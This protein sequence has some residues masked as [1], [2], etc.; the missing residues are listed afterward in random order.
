M[1]ITRLHTQIEDWRKRLL[2][3]SKRNR[4]V[5][6]KI[7]ARA[8]ME[9]VH[10]AP[11]SVWQHLVVDDGTMSFA[12]KR[13][14]LD[15]EDDEDSPQLSLFLGESKSQNGEDSAE[16]TSDKGVQPV[17]KGAEME[18][19]LASP[20]LRE[21]HL[22][23]HMT[24]QTLGSRLKRL[25]LNAKTTIAEQGINV[26]YLT[27]GLLR[28]YESPSSDVPLFAPLL[29]VPVK[30]DRAGPDAPWKISL[31]EEEIA[32]NHCLR[33]LLISNYRLELPE[34]P[35]NVL[36]N[37]GDRAAFLKSVSEVV[38]VP[39][40][41]SRWEVMDR[42]LLAT[43]SFQKLAMWQDLGNNRDRIAA[44]DLCRAIAGDDSAP[45]SASRDLPAI[46]DFDEQIHPKD[47]H[48]ILDSDSSQL[49]AIV[50]AKSGMSLVLDGPPGTGKSQTI[51]NI[52]A[53]SLAAG[54]TVL[55]VS[56]KAAAL[57]VVKR[58]LDASNLGDFC[59]ECHSHKANKKEVI[60]ELGRCL[61]LPSEQYNDQSDELVR[62]KSA[63]KRLNAYVCALHRPCSALR[64][65]PYAVHGQLAQLKASHTSRCPIG[66]VLDVDAVTL[67]EITDALRSLTASHAVIE[68]YD[69]HPWRGCCIARFSLTLQD[70][71]AHDFGHLSQ[72]ISTCAQSV[73]ILSQYGLAPEQPN[74]SQA[75]MTLEQARQLLEFPDLPAQWFARNPR[76]I[77]TQLLELYSVT[78]KYQQL[79]QT[80]SVFRG[81]G[82]GTDLTILLG[83][84]CEK[85]SP[86][87]E[88]LRTSPPVTVRTQQAWFGAL[89]DQLAAVRRL[90]GEIAV[91]VD[92]FSRA[93]RVQIDRGSCIG[94]LTKLTA[95]G[96]ALKQTGLLKG[97]WFDDEKR[98]EL[99]QVA[100]NC[101]KQIDEANRVRNDLSE[102]MSEMAFD[103]E[104]ES[105]SAAA[106]EY[107]QFWK[108]FWCRLMGR[109]GRFVRKSA[110]LY[111][112]PAFANSR[113]LL[114]DMAQLRAY[115]ALTKSVIGEEHLHAAD[116]ICDEQ[117]R[118][119][120]R[121]FTSGIEAIDRL[122][123]I[124]KIPDRLKQV[125]TTEGI[126]DRNALDTAT[127]N[128]DS[129]LNDLDNSV[130]L[131]GEQIVL[132][133]IGTGK[134][135]YVDV[136]PAVFQDWLQAI[137]SVVRQRVATLDGLSAPL[138]ATQD[139]A[140]AD[141]PSYVA[142]LDEL[143]RLQNRQDA[144]CSELDEVLNPNSQIDTTVLSP[145]VETA[146][147]IVRFLDTYGDSPQQGV[148]DVVTRNEPR[149]S[150]SHAC[151]T[152][153]S[154]L[155][156]TVEQAWATLWKCFPADRS[157]AN[158]QDIAGKPL[159]CLG[160]WLGE[161][162]KVVDR[163]QEWIRFRETEEALSRLNVLP[164]LNEVLTGEIPIA[165]AAESY[166]AR[167]YRVWL[168]AA[169]S[170][171]A[172]LREFRA[173]KHESLIST[174]RKLDH[175]AIAGA[176]KRIRAK[177]LADTG[178]PHSGMLAVPPG[179]ELGILL[180]EAGK[181]KRHLALRQLF[182]RIPTLLPR[183]KP[184]L[185]MSP[186]AVSTY[187]DSPDLRFDLV[188]FDEAS[189]V[190]PFDA[191]GAVYRGNQIV[192]AGDQKQLPPT[193]FFDHLVSDDDAEMSDDD[194][195]STSRLSD[196][197]SVLDV[198]CSM[199]MPRKRLRWHYRSR[200]EPLIAFSNHH[201]YA[202]E[203]ATFPSVFDAD[204]TSA[205][206]FHFVSNG[207]WRPGSGGGDN[208]CEARET[209]SLVFQ[210][211]ERHPDQSLGVITFNQ[212]QQFA[213]LDEL[214][215]LRRDR[216]EME[217]FFQED[218]EEPLFVKNLENVQGDERDR[219][220][221]SVGY[222]YDE[223][224]KFA[225]RFG[226]LN[227][228]GGERRLNVAITRAKHQV[229]LVTSIHATDID[230]SR[231]QSAGARLLRAYIDYADRG[232]ETLGSEISED[233]MRQAD[234]PFEM[235]VEGALRSQG[236]DVRRQVGCGGFRIDLAVVHPSQQGRYV[237][238]IECDGATYHSSATARDRDRLRQEIL[239]GLGWTICRV[240]STDWVRNPESQIKRIIQA[241]ETAMSAG[242]CEGVQET[243]PEIRREKPVL[244][245]RRD[246]GRHGT[247]AHGF[248]SIDEVPVDVLDKIILGVLHRYGQ[249]THEELIRATAREL[250]FLRVG[251][252]IEAKIG[253]RI[254]AM[255]GAR[256]VRRADGDRLCAS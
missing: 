90:V 76:R 55:F 2:D 163:L 91:A 9:I 39:T 248:S 199:G 176:Y 60:T 51:A 201:F 175:E 110:T 187:L 8:A 184:C 146:N 107:E 186:L 127:R 125:L 95:L 53:E 213:V 144:L 3:L 147:H 11:E 220:I 179:S 165:E 237:L 235:A 22:L 16:G 143:C 114:E 148:L 123:K 231:V 35:E 48:T 208:P 156:E 13:D 43:F 111:L 193:S 159:S 75:E 19:C 24:D 23:T 224:G 209:A 42:V 68:Q 47:I 81:D 254:A 49:E 71:I 136:P 46:E 54:K 104:G 20:F 7:G 63:R 65:T 217:R 168:D 252:R 236:L 17:A 66:N 139:M 30:L 211:L 245:V 85:I 203:L 21:E 142:R 169:Y 141:L 5:N 10:P 185:M 52:I 173:E 172:T 189:Q 161:Q 80:V 33:E 132:S 6:C 84:G 215:R 34:V 45:V 138:E 61:S 221:I 219:I 216:P 101:Q 223:H 233:R 251:K 135:N 4:L 64:M 40:A 206:Q 121:D 240:W 37:A 116:L 230:L 97:S 94:L 194:E 157:S 62:L 228:Q 44:H 212:R 126:L 128:L 174:F 198:C 225:M 241:F 56:E 181:R 82:I 242:D 25:S 29:L 73:A 18:E 88:F 256:S 38:Q 96:S 158:G 118:A 188:I 27:F 151:A 28:W 171:N 190:R 26:L 154:V 41:H 178:R 99:Q 145:F 155:D 1:P 103:A 58:R 134:T 202:N 105:I 93:L 131:L 133:R 137:E 106:S 92:D 200:R 102:R 255:I 14:L 239:E 70:D 36:E 115:H 195:D 227:V 182:R 183:L 98:T 59:L 246:E 253:K 222:G 214:D 247:S 108:R 69:Q 210:I 67:R 207:R 167:F 83:D 226:P 244:R 197:E 117:G 164:V 109:W 232:T 166:L 32:P 87:L 218:R 229:V 177:L 250:G 86:P 15:E 89:A 100:A 150:V 180:R 238:G 77:A 196:F 191:I 170:D 153:R 249:T 130:N 243:P 50:A 160:A 74:K 79:R 119:R 204:G 31:Y 234:S 205:V 113:E 57:E 122:R 192:V 78:D 152:L 140:V 112:Q 120:W 124:I 129:R 12:W 162:A 72:A 149:L